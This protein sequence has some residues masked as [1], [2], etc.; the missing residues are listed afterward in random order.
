MSRDKEKIIKA[1]EKLK[2]AT[3]ELNDLFDMKDELFYEALVADWP[4][5][6]SFE[7][8]N[9]FVNRW[10]EHSKRTVKKFKD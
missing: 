6:W 1:L 3:N 4:I 9:K 10:V 5:T 7:A 2:E 8:H